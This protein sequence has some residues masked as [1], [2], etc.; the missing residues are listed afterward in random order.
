[1]RK[2]YHSLTVTTVVETISTIQQKAEWNK[3]LNI[4]FGSITGRDLSVGLLFPKQLMK[5][6]ERLN[7]LIGKR[8]I[9]LRIA[10]C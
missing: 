3:R 5:R 9:I 6:S 4:G 2:Q 10:V 8:M 1:M 7:Y